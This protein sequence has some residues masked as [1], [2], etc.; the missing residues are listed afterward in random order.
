M[1]SGNRFYTKK[2]A[3]GVAVAKQSTGN[4]KRYKHNPILKTD[5]KRNIFG[6]G[7]NS[8]VEGANNDLLMFYHVRTS[9]KKKQGTRLTS[10]TPIHF[11]K[12]GNIKIDL[13]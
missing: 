9:K 6:P 8:V 5:I 3:I 11:D 7:H 1:Y 10:Y 4:F 13:K 12:S 2:Y